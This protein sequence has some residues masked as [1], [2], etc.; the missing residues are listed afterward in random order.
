MASH[1]LTMKLNRVHLPVGL[2]LLLSFTVVFWLPVLIL[3]AL[4]FINAEHALK[5][6]TASLARTQ[7]VGAHGILNE[8][9]IILQNILQHV[10]ATESVQQSFAGKKSAQ[11]HE[12]L[13]RLATQAPHARILL[14]VDT[15]LR[16]LARGDGTTGDILEPS[17]LLST[18]LV[19]GRP[20]SSLELVSNAFLAKEGKDLAQRSYGSGIAQLTVVPVKSGD[21][22][23][24]ALI[25]GILLSNDPWLGNSVFDRFG[26][27]AALFAGERIES[28]L[29]HATSSLPRSIWSTGQPMPQAV[30]DAITFG[31]PFS[32]AITIQDTDLVVAFTPV[33]DATSRIIGALGVSAPTQ[34]IRTMVAKKLGISILLAA[35]IGLALALTITFLAARD[36]T[37]PLRF[38]VEAMEQFGRGRID[39]TVEIKTGDEFE[40]LAT[41]FNHMSHD[42]RRR[43]E[44]LT[45]HYQVAKLL[46]STLD[47]DSLLK[48]ML[49]IVVDV[50]ESQMG[51][52]YLHDRE[53]AMLVPGVTFGIKSELRE[54]RADEG[55]PGQAASRRKLHLINPV[56][57]DC[58]QPVIDLGF[59]HRPPHQLAYIPLVCKE[60]L[61][62]ILVLGKLDNYSE[63]ERTLFDYLAHQLA[64][65]LDNA[66]MHKHIHSLSII[67]GLTGLYNRRFLNELL[68]KKWNRAVRHK[69]PLAVMLGDLDNF[70]SINDTHGHSRGDDVLKTVGRVLRESIRTD[71]IGSRYGGEEFVV[72][73]EDTDA[74]NAVALAERIAGRLKE[75][76]FPWLERPVTMSI[77]VAVYPE[78]GTA[79]VEAL[80]QAADH[81]MYEAKTT[82][83]DRVVL[84]APAAP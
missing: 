47:L 33:R 32:G 36:I 52:I 3:S 56:L 63:E 29:L 84:F 30:K 4:F 69:R 80:F 25:G 5:S 62:G 71:D 82:G 8:R 77:G 83:K 57:D 44:K 67:D 12:E 27:E 51:I 19:T 70:K 64:I 46:M 41:G 49:E 10:A 37:R 7:L 79:D 11:L 15:H 23:M 78:A 68:D 26:V 42:V 73:M 20:A 81:A 18:A 66:L 34:E 9:F 1:L 53:T 45:K 55:Y 65:A 6:D 54:L 16:V 24:G 50:T 76:G 43:E 17:Q 31:R 39:T 38:V 48:K 14:A 60:E 40:K 72:V 13:V 59:T 74:K 35:I 58:N 61:L 28:S 21:S 22:V 2:K 75:T